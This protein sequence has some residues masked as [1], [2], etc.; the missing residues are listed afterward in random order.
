MD[1][2]RF[3]GTAAAAG[4]YWALGKPG[5]ALAATGRP[6]LVAARGGEAPALFDRAIAEMGGMKAFVR[7]GQ[8]VLVKPNIGWDRPPELGA[9]TNP[10]LVARIVEQA[11]AAGAGEV[12]VF[13]NSCDDGPRS[14]RTSG[15]EAAARSAGAKVA[16][17]HM[18]SAYHPVKV[19]GKKLTEAK[20]HQLLLEADVF[21]NVPVLKHH[22]SSGLTIGMK[23]LMG[24]VWDRYYWHRTDLLQCIADMA[25]YRK[26]DLVVVDAYRVMKRYGPRSGTAA[27]V[28]EMK[29]QILA[30][31]PVAADAAAARLFGAEVKD[32]AYIE[33]AA[34]A[35][36]GRMDLG[37]LDIRRITL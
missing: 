4:A 13:D 27:D 1:R 28:V 9:N 12:F 25:G 7:K 23:N 22:S 20:V 21:I 3:I 19:P 10:A 14:Y 29:A 37:A 11:L 35:G 33:M 15:I 36:V 18:E 34:A 5:W 16:P 30:T 26:P 31:D 17:G 24:V 32:V 8:K 6:D 2:R